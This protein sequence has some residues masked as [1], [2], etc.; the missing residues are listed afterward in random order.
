MCWALEVP[1][2][3][4]NP[5]TRDSQDLRVRW[6]GRGLRGYLAAAH[7]V[8]H[9]IQVTLPA[10]SRGLRSAAALPRSLI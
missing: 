10:L 1:P 6:S 7:S 2:P 8:H 9:L 4:P 5:V 3:A